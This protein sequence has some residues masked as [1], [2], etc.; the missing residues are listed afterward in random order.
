MRKISNQLN[1][2]SEYLPSSTGYIATLI[3]STI[4]DSFSIVDLH[5]TNDG[6]SLA[7][8]DLND[9]QEYI[10]DIKSNKGQHESTTDR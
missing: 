3:S 4:I 7:I 1:T 8:R 5:R 2:S 10:I 6:Y 9:G